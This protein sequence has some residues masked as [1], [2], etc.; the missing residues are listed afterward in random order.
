[1][2]NL[3]PTTNLSGNFTLNF[4]EFAVVARDII[5]SSTATTIDAISSNHI[6]NE[7]SIIGRFA[8]ELGATS[9]LYNGTNGYISAVVEGIDISGDAFVNNAGTIFGGAVG[10]EHFQGNSLT[11]HNS[12]S[13]VA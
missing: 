1:M 7:G 5:I 12:G 13:I 4:G 11:L 6:D 8:V 9:F 2:A 3:A 10:V